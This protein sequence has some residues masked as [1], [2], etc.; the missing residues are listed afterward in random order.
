MFKIILSAI[1]C[2]IGVVSF[3]NEKEAKTIAEAFIKK[4][5]GKVVIN[6]KHVTYDDLTA[7]YIKG[8]FNPKKVWA[9]NESFSVFQLRCKGTP[10]I[11]YGTTAF[12]WV[13][14][15]YITEEEAIQALR[16]DINY[17]YKRLVRKYEPYFDRLAPHQKAALI[18]YH[19]N[20]GYSPHPRLFKL[21][22]TKPADCWKE[23]DAKGS[24]TRRMKEWA[25]YRG[26][27]K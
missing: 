18:S 15:H 12:K 10:T 14:K 24:E 23:M 20:C 9:D 11:G 22:Q 8:K 16:D 17:V 25:L 21:M 1:I 3:A 5:E 27:I 19:Y 2:L 6:G 4:V 26:E 7:Q 13:S